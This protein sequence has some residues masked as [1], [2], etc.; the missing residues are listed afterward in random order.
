[1]K[2]KIIQV[3]IVAIIALILLV[4]YLNIP[5]SN[6]ITNNTV[7]YP[8]FSDLEQTSYKNS[9]LWNIVNASLELNKTFYSSDSEISDIVEWYENKENI[10]EYEI[11]DGGSR[12]IST[13]NID[14]YN[15][16]YGYVKIHKNNKT[17][18]LFLFAIKSIKEMNIEKENLIGI[19]TGPWDLIKNC[20]KIGNFT[21]L[22]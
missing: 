10:E 9:T 13:T 6:E 12:G 20:K 17:E 8:L 11:I 1:M 19:A 4:A 5:D 22:E 7:S 2:K 3:V 15:I 14:P 18:G 21:S 16:S